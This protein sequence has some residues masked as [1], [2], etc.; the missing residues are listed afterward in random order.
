MSI[1]GTE[2]VMT[3][4]VGEVAAAALALLAIAGAIACPNLA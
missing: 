3:C 4:I 1:L 2:A